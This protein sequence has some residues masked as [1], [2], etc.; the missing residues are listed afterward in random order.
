MERVRG[1][2]WLV[3]LLSQGNTAEGPREILAPSLLE[4]G[5]SMNKYVA[6]PA[7]QNAAEEV[8]FPHPEY[9]ILSCMASG[10]GEKKLGEQRTR[11]SEGTEKIQILPVV[12]WTWSRNLVASHVE[13][14]ACSSPQLA[15]GVSQCSL[16]FTHT[17]TSSAQSWDWFLYKFA[18][19]VVRARLDRQLVVSTHRRL[20]PKSGR[21]QELPCY[22]WWNRRKAVTTWPGVESRDST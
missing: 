22:F 17:H 18:M 10:G 8:Y 7:E 4:G 16:F 11:L 14:V 15:H 2:A 13:Y 19:M 12:S 20:A 6:S 1:T 9:W 3:P 21:K 5:E